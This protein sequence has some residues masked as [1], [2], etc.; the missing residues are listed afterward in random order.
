[1]EQRSTS[2]REIFLERR[3]KAPER[4]IE[5]HNKPEIEGEKLFK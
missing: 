3:G 1:M 5:F 4:K 2:K